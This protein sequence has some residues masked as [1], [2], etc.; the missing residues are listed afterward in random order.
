MA[1]N[2]KKDQFSTC[3]YFWSEHVLFAG[4]APETALHKHHAL[5]ILIGIDKPV[6]LVSGGKVHRHH[7]MILNSGIP[8]QVSGGDYQKIVVH[9]DSET[10]V[11]QKLTHKYL[12]QN[13]ITNLDQQLHNI[14]DQ[15]EMPTGDQSSCEHAEILY[16]L[17]IHSLLE[18]SDLAITIDSRITLAIDI[19]RK[20]EIKKVSTK[21]IADEICLS[22]S[23]LI[24]LFKE[25]IGVP[26]RRYLLW[27]RLIEAIRHVM[28]GKSLTDAA[29]HAGFADYAHLSRTFREMFGNPI[30]TFFKNSQ[31]VHVFS[32]LL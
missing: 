6:E 9:F 10:I 25:Q 24:H 22:E 12:N 23:R 17:I 29:H 3:F 27:L 26:I 15:I 7:S 4:Y 19:I 16:D 28:E 14:F 11:A 5:E 21:Q 32:C 30:S 13:Q 20:L 18:Y 31:F 2:K 1:K 8:H